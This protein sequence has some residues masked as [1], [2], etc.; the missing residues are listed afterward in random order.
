MN[1][2]GRVDYIMSYHMGVL[3][4]RR[5]CLPE[6]WLDRPEVMMRFS[7]E[8]LR[9]IP[10]DVLTGEAQFKCAESVGLANDARTLAFDRNPSLE[11]RR[12]DWREATI[13][14]EVRLV[15]RVFGLESA[16]KVL[17]MSS[18]SRATCCAWAHASSHST[19]RAET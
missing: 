3:Y 18:K 2:D 13:R 19:S 10:D 1:D 16:C 4:A 9:V 12:L 17:L 11:K 15:W 5:R 7:D 14:L 6:F 8:S